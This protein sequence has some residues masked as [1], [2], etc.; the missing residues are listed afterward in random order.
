M[1][2]PPFEC[3]VAASVGE[4]LDAL[5]ADEDAVLIAGG[6][7]LVPMLALRLAAP[8]VLVDVN[9]VSEL[10]GVVRADNGGLSIGAM[11]RQTEL[12]EQPALADRQPLVAETLPY[13]AHHAI[14]NRSTVGGALAHAD[15][16]GEW[17]LLA[18]LLQG[19]IDVATRNGGRRIRAEDFFVG[20][21]TNALGQG[22]L[23]RGIELPPMGSDTGWG[24]HEVARRPGD[25]ALAGAGA[26]VAVHDGEITSARVVLMG[27]TPVPTVLSEVE[28]AL[29]GH[30]P[31]DIFEPLEDAMPAS[32]SFQGDAHAPPEFQ[33]HLSRVVMQRAIQ[34]AAARAH[35][36]EVP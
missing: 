35:G 20:P 11:V 21:L 23:V 31:E 3:V 2:A 16:A 5:T 9:R 22:E 30:R 18:V 36:A 7:S 17:P 26:L 1:K 32:E 15:P 33:R 19:T 8:T 10:Q 24:F 27:T 13:I 4:A 14:R 29:V 34:Q 25:F 6:Q 28:P 12:L